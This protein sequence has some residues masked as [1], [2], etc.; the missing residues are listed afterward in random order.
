MATAIAQKML[1]INALDAP[2]VKTVHGE[3][4]ARIVSPAFLVILEMGELV[5]VIFENE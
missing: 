5:K 4:I 2:N 3:N 1:P